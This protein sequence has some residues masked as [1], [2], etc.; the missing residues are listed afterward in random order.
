MF[1][2][3][4][5]LARN[6]N[7]AY[8]MI[9]LLEVYQIKI[10]ECQNNIDT[11]KDDGR[12]RMAIYF[13]LSEKEHDMIRTRSMN[14]TKAKQK[15]LGWTGGRVPFGYMK[16]DNN[17]DSIPVINPEESETIRLIYDMYWNQHVRVSDIKSYLVL[18]K[19]ETG[20]YNKTGW[21]VKAITRIKKI[22]FILLFKPFSIFL[23]KI[24][25]YKKTVV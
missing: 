21:N 9:S 7:V 24:I 8:A 1:H 6:S 19:I 4:D 16:P 10:I 23:T 2:A 3:F 17:K 11:S 22:N 14:G 15:K 5:R 13:A 18:N 25:N 12:F 20:K